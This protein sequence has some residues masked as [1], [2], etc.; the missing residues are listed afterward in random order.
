MYTQIQLSL[1]NGTTTS[2]ADASMWLPM[3][4]GGAHY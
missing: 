2:Q 4:G 3:L 1:E